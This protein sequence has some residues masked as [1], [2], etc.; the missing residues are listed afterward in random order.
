MSEAPFPDGKTP[1]KLTPVWRAL[2]EVG[3]IVFL[4][5]SNLLMGE[6]E[7]SG[8]GPSRGLSYALLDVVTGTN[9]VIAI[10]TALVGYLVF[11]FLRKR[12]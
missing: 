2:I 3:F 4:Y 11:E 12:F 5:Y 6:Y 7:R 8:K 9:L 1:R 10:A